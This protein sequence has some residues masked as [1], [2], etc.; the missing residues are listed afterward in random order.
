MMKKL[1]FILILLVIII[2]TGCNR[3][4][5]ATEFLKDFE[6]VT[7]E[8]SEKL[9]EGDINGARKFYDD[10]K[11]QLVRKWNYLRDSRQFQ[12]SD[13]MKK[14]MNTEPVAEMTKVVKSANKAIEKYPAE[15]QK[16]QGIVNDLSNLL[17]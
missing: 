16:I 14:K 17:K 11:V 5:R 13:A 3:D 10:E 4:S 7:T 15:T 1:S 8:I 12:F 6:R 9:D 2:F